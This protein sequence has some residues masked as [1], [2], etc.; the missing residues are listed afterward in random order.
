LRSG[1]MELSKESQ[2]FTYRM[3]EWLV[4]VNHKKATAQIVYAHL[5]CVWRQ[6]LED[7]EPVE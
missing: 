5:K 3:N 2:S 7:Q 6:N 1:E 4:I